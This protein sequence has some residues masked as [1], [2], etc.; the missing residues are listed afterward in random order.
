MRYCMIQYL[1]KDMHIEK[2]ISDIVYVKKILRPSK[3]KR[4]N[5]VSREVEWLKKLSNWDRI[6]HLIEYDDY[7][8]IM[9]YVGEKLCCHNIPYDW[10]HQALEII[11]ELKA[12]NCSHNDIYNEELLVMNG[13]IHLIDFHHATIL[14]DNMTAEEFAKNKIHFRVAEPDGDRIINICKKIWEEKND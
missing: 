1:N 3:R 8:V 4:W 13:K 5:F 14:R 7:V 10:E 12:R 2:N 11:E 9:S 6:P